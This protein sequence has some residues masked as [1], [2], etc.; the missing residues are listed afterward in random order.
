MIATNALQT[1]ETFLPGK[2]CLVDYTK[3]RRDLKYEVLAHPRTYVYIVLTSSEY[4][5]RETLAGQ[6]DHDSVIKGF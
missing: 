5:D 4:H 3:I 1:R 6:D 2:S